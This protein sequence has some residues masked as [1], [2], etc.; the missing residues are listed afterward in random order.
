MKITIRAW[1]DGVF[2][3]REVDALP[4]GVPGLAVHRAHEGGG[5]VISHIKTG[6]IVAAFP[7]EV[8]DCAAG[9]GELGDW[10]EM[11]DPAARAA[12]AEIIAGY[13]AL[14]EQP[15]AP[16]TVIAA[17]LERAGMTGAA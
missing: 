5:M 2:T 6:M 1:D 4:A 8:F 9:L 14:V 10:Q 13:D 15:D 16:Q 17:E 3:D 12:A 7:C 11:P